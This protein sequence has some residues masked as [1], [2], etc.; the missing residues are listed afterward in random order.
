M[1]LAVG[2]E[3]LMFGRLCTKSLKSHLRQL[4]DSSSSTY[5][6]RLGWSSESP[7]RQLRD[8]SNTASLASFNGNRQDLNHPP[9]PAGGIQSAISI[10][11]SAISKRRSHDHRFGSLAGR[12]IVGRSIG[13]AHRCRWMRLRVW[14]QRYWL[15]IWYVRISWIVRHHWSFNVHRSK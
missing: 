15:R 11:Q 7:Q 3:L 12:T 10:Q 5:E 4:V 2:E 9:A 8:V 6:E 13:L 1:R 14:W